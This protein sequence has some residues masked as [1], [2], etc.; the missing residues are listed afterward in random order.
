MVF[1]GPFQSVSSCARQAPR[2]LGRLTFLSVHVGPLTNIGPFAVVP[3]DYIVT[4]TTV[5]Q[6]RP[7]FSGW[8][9]FS[10]AQILAARPPE[11]PAP[12]EKVVD[13]SR[14]F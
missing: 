14:P 12:D 9:Q 2:Y 6:M 3:E 1:T 7:G 4:L 5:S 10:R 11:Q 13:L 8:P